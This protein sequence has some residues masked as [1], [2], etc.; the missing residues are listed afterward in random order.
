VLPDTWAGKSLRDLGLHGLVN[1]VAVTRA[2]APR[3]D[4]ANLV[5]Q[6]GDVLHLAVLKEGIEDLERLLEHRP[7][8]ADGQGRAA[9]S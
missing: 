8:T 7:K 4:V 6:E 2:G 9:R 1:V 3:L 5:G